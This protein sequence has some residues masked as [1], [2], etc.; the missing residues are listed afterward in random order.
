[1]LERAESLVLQVQRS[2]DVPEEILLL[3]RYPS[4]ELQGKIDEIATKIENGSPQI[5]GKSK[6]DQNGSD[7]ARVLPSNVVEIRDVE[8]ERIQQSSDEVVE[9]CKDTKSVF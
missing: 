9:L 3:S 8:I 7:I 1:M 6:A 4:Q 2:K 5:N